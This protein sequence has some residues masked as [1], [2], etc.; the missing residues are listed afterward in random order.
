MS[1][2]KKIHRLVAEAFI[3]NPLGKPEV[4]HLNGK[5]DNRV[6][7]LIWATTSENI[8]HAYKNGLKKPIKG[9]K[10]ILSKKVV[11]LDLYGNIIKNWNCIN[12]AKKQLKINNI[13]A[14]CRGKYKTAGRFYM[15]I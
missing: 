10:N 9:G 6:E 12:D 13:S 7:S 4:N 14:C 8:Q 11:Q 1:K 5:E 2:T 3:P 15:E